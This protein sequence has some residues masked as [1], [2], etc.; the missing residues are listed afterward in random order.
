VR[1]LLRAA[2]GQ[3]LRVMIPM[4]SMAA[5]MDLV[6]VL[7]EKE[8][9]IMVKR[10]QEGPKKVLV[11]A[12]I[13]VPC[14]LFELD[15]LMKKADFV[16]VG[17]NDLLQFMYAA[18]RTN[19]RVGSRYDSLAAAPL[20]ALKALV[21]AAEKHSVPLTLCGEMAGRPIE[22][23]ALIAL[24]FRSLSMAPASIGPVKT[25]IL[26]LHAERSAKLVDEMLK[27]GTPNIRERLD[28]FA[29]S[30]GIDL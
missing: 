14:L 7:I 6:R 21:K 8:R 27:K 1:A 23:L 12:M 30:E 16:S 29:K 20:R 13:E 26:A 2:A 9:A 17:S 22:A 5:E 18:D 28:S 15:A 25:M 19:A 4:V 10:K 3:E 11:G 24:G